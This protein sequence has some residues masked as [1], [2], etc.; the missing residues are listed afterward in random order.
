METQ[1]VSERVERVVPAL[2]R[3][4]RPDGLDEIGPSRRG[5]DGR[6]HPES[7]LA[8]PV[9]RAR[10]H[11][12]NVSAEDIQERDA[13]PVHGPFAPPRG[14]PGRAGIRLLHLSNPPLDVRLDA[15]ARATEEIDDQLAVFRI[16]SRFREH[17]LG[18]T[19]RG[20]RRPD[21][22]AVWRGEVQAALKG[23]SREGERGQDEEQRQHAAS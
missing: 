19:H 4:C 11:F 3:L 14:F 15:A 16:T 13:E 21:R 18:N 20:S 17:E 7:R 22:P 2:H 10:A 9:G 8:V 5:H 1:A 12:G 23:S 6:A